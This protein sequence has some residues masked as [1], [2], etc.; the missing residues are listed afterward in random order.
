MNK[1]L[2]CG[3]ETTNPKFCS[4]S[5]SASYN[6]RQ[7]PKRG[8]GRPKYCKNCGKELVGR[9]RE[10]IFCN[11]FCSQE[12]KYKSYINRWLNGEETGNRGKAQTYLSFY[13]RRWI[14]ERD[15]NTCQHC[16][17]SKFHPKTEKSILQI[18]HID[19]NPK[20]SKP[21][22]LILADSWDTKKGNGRRILEKELDSKY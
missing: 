14:F 6:N 18:H 2:T 1:C 13:V 12:Y 20:N 7:Y 11:H 21:E 10:Q 3:K 17:F 9:K 4:R 19:E 22:N 5:C 8:D 15:N 16:G